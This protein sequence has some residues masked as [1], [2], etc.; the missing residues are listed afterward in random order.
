MWCII[1]TFTFSVVLYRI[2][3]SACSS[4][5]HKMVALNITEV[6]SVNL[7]FLLNG[8]HLH[9][10]TY[11]TTI[12][13]ILNPNLLELQWGNLRSRKRLYCYISL[14]VDIWYLMQINMQG[15]IRI[16]FNLFKDIINSW[17]ALT[18]FGELYAP[19]FLIISTSN[20]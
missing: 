17:K 18:L 11:I 15:V 10:I 16:K 2:L 8:F 6:K 13:L 7:E 4:R 12:F 14:V 1:A 20:S 5:I 3:W 9:F 19:R